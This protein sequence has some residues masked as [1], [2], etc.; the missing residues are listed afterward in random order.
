MSTF[1][2]PM[3]SGLS[4]HGALL[5][6]GESLQHAST[7]TKTRSIRDV[8]DICDHVAPAICGLQL[9]LARVGP[10]FLLQYLQLLLDLNI[11]ANL[12]KLMSLSL[13][14]GYPMVQ[15]LGAARDCTKVAAQTWGLSSEL[16]RDLLVICHK[17]PDEPDFE[18]CKAVVD[19]L[20]PFTSDGAPGENLAT[21]KYVMI[22]HS[23]SIPSR[24]KRPHA[25]MH[26]I[27]FVDVLLE[28]LATP[29]TPL[30]CSC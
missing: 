7:R 9:W 26:P 18:L 17:C 6:L 13:R 5:K 19:Q 23:L 27:T 11:P 10:S 25:L 12:V 20:Q 8:A 30:T 4:P 2:V 15:P 29:Y 22:L 28:S 14:A 16:F 1:S 3:D 24:P 21:F